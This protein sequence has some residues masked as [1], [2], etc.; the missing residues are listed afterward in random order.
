MG[1]IGSSLGNT[2]LGSSGNVTDNI[3]LA[4]TNP[5]EYLSGATGLDHLKALTQSP[6]STFCANGW[7]YEPNAKLFERG[8]TNFYEWRRPVWLS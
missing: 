5:G 2:I 6:E 8:A 1:N 3:N 7:F 4:V